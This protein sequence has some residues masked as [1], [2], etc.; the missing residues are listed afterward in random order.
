MI[1]QEDEV[2]YLLGEVDPFN[3]NKMTY[4]EIVQLL[5]NHMV[6]NHDDPSLP[7]QSIPILEKF[8]LIS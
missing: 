7:Q 8:S 1:S 2:I 4:S 5:S 6:T 3:N